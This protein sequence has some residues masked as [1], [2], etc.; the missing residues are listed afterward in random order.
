MI[1]LCNNLINQGTKWK[2]KFIMEM[3]LHITRNKSP[4]I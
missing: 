4:N 1:K 3:K 2:Q